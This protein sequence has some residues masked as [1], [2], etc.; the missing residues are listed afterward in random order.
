MDNSVFNR[1]REI[2]HNIGSR[3]KVNHGT[4]TIVGYEIVANR[5][6]GKCALIF[7]PIVS[8]VDGK[9]VVDDIGGE[10]DQD[11]EPKREFL[12]YVIILDEGHTW[13][14]NRKYYCSWA[15]QLEIIK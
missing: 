4:G 6:T 15:D 12:R 14:T 5:A 10:P 8:Y 7:D 3:V 1:F 2:E 13:I 9:I 11:G